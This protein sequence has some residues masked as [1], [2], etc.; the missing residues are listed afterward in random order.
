MIPGRSY[1]GPYTIPGRSYSGPYMIPSRPWQDHSKEICMI[2]MVP[3]YGQIMIG[4]FGKPGLR[5]VVCQT[6]ANEY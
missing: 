2:S 5:K 4:L 1:S 6:F 3:L